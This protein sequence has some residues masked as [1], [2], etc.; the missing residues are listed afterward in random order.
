MLRVIGTRLRA[1]AP[2]SVTVARLGADEVCLAY[3]DV[4]ADDLTA[5]AARLRTVVR[6]SVV[7]AGRAGICMIA[8]PSRI[9]SVC[10][11]RCPR[12]LTAS[13]P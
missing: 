8:V 10:A 2:A 12:M 11:A 9:R 13:D 1:A 3:P 6:Q 7:V 5:I 4:T